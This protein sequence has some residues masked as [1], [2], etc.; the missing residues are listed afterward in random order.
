MRKSIPLDR[1]SASVARWLADAVA[2]VPN[3]TLPGLA[4]ACAI[5]PFR[6]VAGTLG[7]IARAIGARANNAIGWKPGT[8]CE[9]GVAIAI[10]VVVKVD[11]LKRSVYPL[12]WALATIP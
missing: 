1:L 8:H 4:L 5:K 9:G 11:A 3:V 2:A 10:G 12:G 7:F 6:S